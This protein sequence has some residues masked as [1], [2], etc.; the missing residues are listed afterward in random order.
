MNEVKV[1][2]ENWSIAYTIEL[3]MHARGCLAR[4]KR[5]GRTRLKPNATLPF[6]VLSKP[7]KSILNSIVYN[8]GVYYLFITKNWHFGAKEVLLLSFITLAHMSAAY[9]RGASKYW[10]MN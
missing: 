6:C 9:N 5:R 7:L 4:K 10:T 2:A 3:W 8:C 1:I